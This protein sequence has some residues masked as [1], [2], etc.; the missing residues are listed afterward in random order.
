M[1]WVW[2]VVMLWYWSWSG[3]P[4]YQIGC[5]IVFYY[6]LIVHVIIYLV[7]VIR[8]SQEIYISLLLINEIDLLFRKPGLVLDLL[9][10]KEW[11]IH[12]HLW[13]SLPTLAWDIFVFVMPTIWPS[14]V[15]RI[16]FLS[17]MLSLWFSSQFSHPFLF[18]QPYIW[19]NHRSPGKYKSTEKSVMA[20]SKI[21]FLDLKIIPI[22]MEPET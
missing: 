19:Q 3:L 16:I 14:K 4:Q 20:L 17:H 2:F 12:T 1:V 5:H 11:C 18:L 15:A 13:V 8:F 6:F 21:K 10:L 9:F 22:L 7:I